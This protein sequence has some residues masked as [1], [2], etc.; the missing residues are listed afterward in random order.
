MKF[1]IRRTSERYED[2]DLHLSK[3]WE[4][5]K[6][7]YDGIDR[8]TF[9]TFDEYEAHCH[10][11][12]TDRGMD[13]KK[14]RGGIERVFPNNHTGQ[15]LEINSL[16]DLMSLHDECGDLIISTALFNYNIPEIEIYD[17]YRE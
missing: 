9:K 15:F 14:I 2:G 7:K 16:E 1:L 4:I 12:W 3:K 17:D 10:E 5:K 8:R 6:E 11:K 13:H